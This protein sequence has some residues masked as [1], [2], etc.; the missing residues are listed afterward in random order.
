MTVLSPKL[1]RNRGVLREKLHIW[2]MSLRSIDE[3]RVGP[4]FRFD[5]VIAALLAPISRVNFA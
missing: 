4:S 3:P 5:I 1:I 2:L